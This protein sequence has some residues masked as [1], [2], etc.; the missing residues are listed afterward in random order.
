MLARV[1]L[2]GIAAAQPQE[3][4]S[5]TNTSTSITGVESGGEQTGILPEWS[6]WS[7]A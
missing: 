7:G 1:W 2:E 5:N 6:H 3:I 4:V